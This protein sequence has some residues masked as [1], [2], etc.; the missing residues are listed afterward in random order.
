MPSDDRT[1]DYDDAPATTARDDDVQRQEAGRDEDAIVGRTVTIGRPRD[2][3][4]AFWRH[5]PNLAGVMENIERIDLVDD[6][7]SR[8]LVKGPGGKSFEWEAV[9]TEDEPGRLLAWQ[10]VEGSDISHSG[11]VEFFDAAPGRGTMVRATLAYDPPG[12]LIGEWIAK[13]FQREPN[14]QAR[15]DLRRLKQFLETGE[16]SSSASPSARRSESP[17]EQAL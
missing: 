8:W 7:R 6:R 9:I 12:G 17:T 16:I 1:R 4:Y 14:L 11:R 5:L 10:S 15:R 13:L 2:E 3:I